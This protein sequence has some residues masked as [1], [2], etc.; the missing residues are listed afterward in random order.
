MRT[1]AVCS[2]TFRT[3]TTQNTANKNNKMRDIS[4]L[5][6]CVHEKTTRLIPFVTNTRVTYSTKTRSSSQLCAAPRH[7]IDR[8]IDYWHCELRRK[9]NRYSYSTQCASLQRSRTFGGYNWISIAALNLSKNIKH[10]IYKQFFMTEMDY[11][12][13]IFYFIF[14]F[15]KISSNYQL[16]LRDLQSSFSNSMP[17]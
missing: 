17:Y 5:Q 3:R 9:R 14:D 12:R 10:N 11:D 1:W 13:L 8:P 15:H 16:L 6:E 4:V 2:L 7:F